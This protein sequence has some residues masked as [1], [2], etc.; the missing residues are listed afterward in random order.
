MTSQLWHGA[1]Y[2]FEEILRLFRLSRGLH[3]WNFVYGVA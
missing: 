2:R 1:V 3:G